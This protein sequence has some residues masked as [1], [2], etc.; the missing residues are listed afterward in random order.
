[1]SHIGQF[2]TA[3]QKINKVVLF[4][5]SGTVN[6]SG[7]NTVLQQIKHFA[8]HAEC[9]QPTLAA[10]NPVLV[11]LYILTGKKRYPHD[12]TKDHELSFLRWQDR[13]AI[14]EK[15]TT[16]IDNI[17]DP[18][19][20][21][22]VS[23]H[24]EYF[25][26]LVKYHLYFLKNEL[27]YRGYD[28]T[29]DSLCLGKWKE[30]IK[31]QL[32]TNPRFQEL[33]SKVTSKHKKYDYTSK[34][35]CCEMVEIIAE[36]V[37]ESIITDVNE[38][39]MFSILI[40]ECKDNAGHEELSLCFRYL[41]EGVVNERFHSLHRV[42]D[43]D[44]EHLV[45][46]HIQPTLKSSN[47]T[48]LLVGGG[49][50]GASVMSGCHEGV[51]AK[52]QQYYDCLIYIHCAAHRLNLVVSSFLS[53]SADA[54]KVIS[55]YKALHTI[56][57]VANNKEV[58]EEEQLRMFPGDPV[59]SIGQL[60]EVRW[61]CKFEGINTMISCIKPLLTSLQKIAGG[62]S[63]KADAA[64]GA[65]HKILS[66]SFIT[67]LVFLHEV[68][69]ITDGLNRLLQEKTVDWVTARCE[70]EVCK[71]L[72]REL[73]T[74]KMAEKVGKICLD[75][76]ITTEYED[77]VHATRKTLS[78]YFRLTDA[79]GKTT[80]EQTLD[81]MKKNTTDKILKDMSHRFDG[82]SSILISAINTLDA[83]SNT[84]LDYDAMKPL[85]LH[86]KE[87]QLNDVLLQS[88]CQRAKLSLATGQSIIPRLYPNLQKLIQL[89]KTL[90][91]ST[92]TVER[93]FS[94]MRRIISNVRNRLTTKHASDFMLTS[95]NKD[96]L[97]EINISDVID[98]WASK[99]ARH[100]KLS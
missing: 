78:D 58:F 65:Y 76:D 2:Y 23:E 47:I 51:F 69:A 83:A 39:D 88:E 73:N 7:L 48:A 82:M 49:A 12:S 74:D 95:L 98:R 36:F 53:G 25:T 5:K 57:N 11:V 81:K 26:L 70:F 63:N 28:E 96:K 21:S 72:L 17:L 60:T 33:H 14:K 99:K 79:E 18:D 94:C 90:P 85:L 64:A 9:T 52:L 22:A 44:A 34:H 6:S 42:P 71:K 50:D 97:D 37:R 55:V 89:S 100:V 19:R 13:I 4:I 20:L 3:I 15:K 41:K 91:V 68:L 77:P 29:D 30:F 16:S 31:L 66:S 93:G 56:L 92:A 87:L 54:K 46:D 35:T 38:A 32:D 80:V 86:Y 43:A 8:F 1:M 75:I 24:R 67:A 61:S 84:Y 40:D 59:K 27:P 10:L 62:T 45:E